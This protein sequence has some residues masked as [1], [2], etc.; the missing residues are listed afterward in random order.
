[1]SDKL[2]GFELQ[3]ECLLCEKEIP[4]YLYE[5]SPKVCSECKTA[6]AILKEKLRQEADVNA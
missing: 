6:I 5:S 4:I 1:M 3:I 2:K